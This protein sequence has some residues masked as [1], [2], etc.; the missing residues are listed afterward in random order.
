[1]LTAN[2]IVFSSLKEE[3]VE[4][5]KYDVGGGGRKAHGFSIVKG[6][7]LQGRRG[8]SYS[9]LPISSA[10]PCLGKQGLSMCSGLFGSV[11]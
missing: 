2:H 11:S 8:N 5:T 7:F 1:M 10:W 6:K 4:G 9:L 3:E